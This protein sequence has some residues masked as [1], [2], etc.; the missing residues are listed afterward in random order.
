MYKD[1]E[2]VSGLDGNNNKLINNSNRLEIGAKVDGQI[3]PYS[4]CFLKDAIHRI[5]MKCFSAELVK[6][7]TL[8]PSI[9]ICFNKPIDPEFLIAPFEIPALSTVDPDIAY[10]TYEPNFLK[11]YGDPAIIVTK[12]C[13]MYIQTTEPPAKRY[14]LQTSLPPSVS[15]AVLRH[16]FPSREL[17]LHLINTTLDSLEM[18]VDNMRLHN[19]RHWL[20]YVCAADDATE[21]PKHQSMF[22][23]AEYH[24]FMPFGT[25][26]FRGSQVTPTTVPYCKTV[27]RKKPVR[28]CNLADAALA[29]LPLK[30]FKRNAK[31]LEG[32][33]DLNLKVDEYRQATGKKKP[34]IVSARRL[35]PIVNGMKKSYDMEVART[36][37]KK[38]LNDEF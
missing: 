17:Q 6:Y 8:I 12:G 37:D 32:P 27:V 22:S 4:E 1:I 20:F 33:T 9:I 13:F 7:Q 29:S 35:Q 10:C 3:L 15:V 38:L 30:F 11:A 2:L 14:I 24:Y 26:I 16:R 31:L 18:V 23:D 5:S 34:R 28:V 36:I 25:T 19:A 21:F